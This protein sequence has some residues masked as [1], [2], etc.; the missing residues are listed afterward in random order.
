MYDHHLKC[1]G[2]VKKNPKLI[3]AVKD[4]KTFDL[5]AHKDEM[6]RATWYVASA[7][8]DVIDNTYLGIYIYRHS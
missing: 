2:L 1:G 6:G 5:V 4:Y 8:E 7:V 3:S